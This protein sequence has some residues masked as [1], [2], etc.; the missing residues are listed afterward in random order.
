M[1]SPS[2]TT[3]TP[4]SPPWRHYWPAVTL[5]F[6]GLIITTAAAWQID[7]WAQAR[8]S[9]RFTAEA[10]LVV[11][12]IEQK[13]ERYETA[14]SRLRDAC[15]QSRGMIPYADWAGWIS[16]NLGMGHN[17]PNAACVLLAP[18]V[19]RDQA[20][21]FKKRAQAEVGQHPG[22]IVTARAG[23]DFW[24]PVWRQYNSGWV[25][26]RFLGNDL[27][28]ER[29]QLHSF[30]PALKSTFGWVGPRP[31]H[32]LTQKGDSR[33]GFWF[34]I[35]LRPLDNYVRIR[36]Q[37][38]SET[39]EDTVNRQARQR[40]DE[41]T[42]LLAA[43]LD[44]EGFLQEFNETNSNTRVQ[45]FTSQTLGSQSLV[46]PT[47]TPPPTPL[48][49]MNLPMRWYGRGWTARVVSS[50][51]FESGSLRYR[52][53][54]VRG[55]GGVMSLGG[56]LVVAW[57]I[58]GR[59]REST[60]AAQ[61]REALSRQERISRDLH[62]GTLQ[63]VYGI[64]LALQRAQK[65]AH[66]RPADLARQLTETAGALQR[67]ILE[68]R[69]FIRQT[70]PGGRE[71]VPLG[72]ALAGVVDHQR[73]GTDME[74]SLVVTPGTGTQLTPTHSLQLLNIAREALSNSIRHSQA[75]N[76][77]ILLDQSGDLVRLTVADDGVGF[78][79]NSQQHPGRGL[80]NLRARVRE[81][82]GHHRWEK[83]EP[84]GSCLVVEVPTTPSVPLTS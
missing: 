80:S 38:P 16:R 45:L 65:L 41:I 58:R 40:A 44:G 56:A 27:L 62:D 55:V 12:M 2:A 42:G 25:A 3:S 54:L 61:L 43:F 7:R 46:N 49:A 32:L 52:T 64:G 1:S 17:F 19:T 57:A 18:R 22:D 37:F 51:V 15:S 21:T 10:Q 24:F 59:W 4:A 13:M 84:S 28:S 76:V 81:L 83:V 20:E 50:P 75:R 29:E 68:L 63:S 48:I 66:H 14:L 73:L 6:G 77:R 69:D 39:P 79:W 72:E 67:V 36:G 8:D 26:T 11:K 34:T 70:D 47:H 53:W 71:E 5:A 35:P 23:A 74:L 33:V 82:R 31:A 60:L 78:D 9:E 30:E